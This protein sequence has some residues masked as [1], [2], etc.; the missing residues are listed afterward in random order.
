MSV[1]WKLKNGGFINSNHVVTITR[2]SVHDQE[3]GKVPDPVRYALSVTDTN[4]KI[5]RL[6]GE[7]D[8]PEEADRAIQEAVR[9]IALGN[10]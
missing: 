10:V 9:D 3:V 8:T 2:V 1:F 6:D 5:W 7:Y 4:N